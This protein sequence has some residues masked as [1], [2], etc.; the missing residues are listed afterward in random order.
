LTDATSPTSADAH[1]RGPLPAL[2]VALPAREVLARAESLAKRGRL[3]GFARANGPALFTALAFGTPFDHQLIAEA[4][5]AGPMTAVRFRLRML[6]RTPLIFAVVIALSIWP[7][8]WLTD[9]MLRTYFEGYPLSP[10]QT[11]AWYIPLTV[12]PLPIWLVRAVKRSRDAAA[13][14]ARELIDRLRVALGV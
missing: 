13:S 4:S 5:T 6:P 2:A 10:W 9:S 8:V 12:L 1:A 7:G 11:A 3:P 14:E